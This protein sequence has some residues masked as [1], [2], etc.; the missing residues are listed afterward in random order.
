MVGLN[1]QPHPLPARR[2]DEALLGTLGVAAVSLPTPTAQPPSPFE[3]PNRRAGAKT[4]GALASTGI[5]QD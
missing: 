5:R 1:H 3:Y 2:L 4:S